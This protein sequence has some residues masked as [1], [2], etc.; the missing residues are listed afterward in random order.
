MSDK[1]ERRDFLKTSIA[2]AGAIGA[3][4]G[5]DEVL[6]APAIDS[7]RSPVLGA[8]DQ[9]R[10]GLIGC[11]GQGNWDS[12][13]FARLPDVKIVALC[14]VYEGSIQKTMLNPGLKLD[15][16]KTPTYKDFRKLLEDK[17]IDA[18]IIATPDHWHQQIA[19]EAMKAGKDVYCEKPVVQRLDEGQAVIETQNATKRILQVGSQFV[20]S[21]VYQ[22]AKEILAS[23]AIG[24]LNLVDS[25][26][27]R[28]GAMSA[29]QYSIPPDASPQTC[30]WE[31]FQGRAPKTAW[32]PKRFFRWRNY[33][34][35]GTGIGGDLFVHQF[36][37]AHFVT[38]S[39]GPTRVFATGGLRLWND[40]RDVPDVLLG[41]FDYPKT[42]AH[43]AFT[44]NFR[45]SFADGGTDQSGWGTWVY[46]FVGSDGVIELGDDLIVKRPPPTREPGTAIDTFTEATQ[47]EF[48]KEYRKQYPKGEPALR[49]IPE[50]RY[51]P[52]A[53]YDERL[54]H[55]KNFFRAM[56]TRQPAVEDAAFGFRAAAPAL[57]A[58]VSY[59]EN[60]IV[61]WDPESMRQ[62]GGKV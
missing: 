56:R 36:T 25:S 19:I 47:A 21:I 61:E 46:R 30:D 50:V 42:D 13:D 28:R 38:G 27:W 45:V 41:L 35:Y 8:N 48:M 10:V 3:A 11:G 12:G 52:P 58:N 17:N 59:F 29:W 6:G 15:P 5:A 60:R 43:P 37:S 23:G 53:K 4:A 2:A 39:K 40:G 20:S 14:D 24:Q 34:D 9:V 62:K 49:E 44:M 51:T 31:R 1:M 54:D 7:V 57:M 16:A 22:K 18:V 32:D 26:L 55:F 33:R